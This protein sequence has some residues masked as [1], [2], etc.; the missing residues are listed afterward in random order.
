MSR[1]T[2]LI[3]GAVFL[4]ALTAHFGYHA[5]RETQV[6]SQWMVIEGLDRPSALARYVERQDFFIGYAYALAAAFTAFAV[7]LS[8]QQRRREVGGVGITTVSVVLSG[9]YI[10]R[11]SRR[12]CCA[13]VSET[14]PVPRKP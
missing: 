4:V 7:T 8:V 6:A 13:P 1:L 9:A 5:W 12:E 3:G 11:R 2:L 14:H 10:V